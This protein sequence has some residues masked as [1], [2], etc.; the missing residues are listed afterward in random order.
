[1]HNLDLVDWNAQT[2]RD[3]L[4]EGGF[5]TL[6]MRVGSGEHFNIAGRVDPD[7]GTFPEAHA[8]TKRPHR[9]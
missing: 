7:F 4:S 2:V 5:M 6:A 1:M 3:Q 8:G 9:S